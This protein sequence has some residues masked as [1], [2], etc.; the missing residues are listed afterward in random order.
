[1]LWEEISSP[2][3]TACCQ[4]K[5]DDSK[6]INS[7]LP[8]NL[9]GNLWVKVVS[10]EHLRNVVLCSSAAP[11]PSSDCWAKPFY[12]PDCVRSSLCG[13]IW[14]V[15][16]RGLQQLP[17][18]LSL[19]SVRWEAT[20]TKVTKQLSIKYFFLSF[21]HNCIFPEQL[22][23]SQAKIIVWS[24]R[25]SLMCIKIPFLFASVSIKDGWWEKHPL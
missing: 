3:S 9:S 18:F 11:N 22:E 1:M 21:N 16:W 17:R 4:S 7:H 5:G 2:F 20:L 10:C 19:Y 15:I 8:P 25:G 14:S 24:R 23:A 6:S 12:C 13:N